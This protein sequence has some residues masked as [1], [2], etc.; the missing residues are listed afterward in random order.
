MIVWG[1][2]FV[3]IVNVVFVGWIYLFFKYVLYVCFVDYF[4]LV[5]VLWCIRDMVYCFCLLYFYINI[6]FYIWFIKLNKFSFYGGV[7]ESFERFF[8]SVWVWICIIFCDF[9]IWL[10]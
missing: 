6:L 9:I 4:M 5:E 10:W 8:L 3:S 2:G 1:V 7:D